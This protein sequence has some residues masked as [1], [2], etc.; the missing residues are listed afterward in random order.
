MPNDDDG[1]PMRMPPGKKHALEQV[2]PE[3]HDEEAVIL[4]AGQKRARPTHYVDDLPP[5]PD[6]DEP[7]HN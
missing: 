4:P 3:G 1:E 5:D 7:C 6:D 2:L